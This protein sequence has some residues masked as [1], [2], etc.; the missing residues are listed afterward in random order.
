MSLYSEIIYDLIKKDFIKELYRFQG[1]YSYDY[2][3]TKTSSFNITPNDSYVYLSG[4]LDHHK[5]F[6]IKRI[7]QLINRDVLSDTPYRISNKDLSN[8]ETYSIIKKL[9][10]KSEKLVDL[11]SVRLITNSYA[12]SLMKSNSFLQNRKIKGKPIERVDIKVFGGGYGISEEWKDLLINLTYFDGYQKIDKKAII[13]L[14]TKMKTTGK[15]DNK[16]NFDFILGNSKSYSYKLSPR[17]ESEL[18]KYKIMDSLDR[19]LEKGTYSKASELGENPKE[20]IRKVVEEYERGKEKVLTILD[21]RYN[22]K[23]DET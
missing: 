11:Y 12:I 5:Y 6:S 22:R 19:I 21:G 13:N 9:V 7:K 14:I 15:L 2:Y 16:D 10:L 1:S 18:T 8:I 17:L 23:S 20:T 3:N 4:S